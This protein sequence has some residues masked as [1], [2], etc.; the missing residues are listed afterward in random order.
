[1]GT[2]FIDTGGSSAFSGSSDSAAADLI[3]IS[4]SA[5]G[6]VVTL[7]AGTVLTGVI[8][9]PGPTQS[10]INLAGATNANRTIFW[11][12]AVAGSGGATPTVTV[13]VA[14]TGGPGGGWA[15]GGQYL[16]PSGGGAVVWEAACRSGDLIQYNQTPVSRTAAHF[17]GRNDAAGGSAPCRIIGKAGVRP[18][19]VVTNTANVISWGSLSNYLIEDL[20]IEQQGTSGNAVNCTGAGTGQ[21][22]RNVRI[23]D[24]G[25][26]GYSSA[27]NTAAIVQG[28]EIS[29]VLGDGV[30]TTGTVTFYGNNIHDNGGDGYENSSTSPSPNVY[31]NL[32]H[33]NYGRGIAFTGASSAATHLAQ[34]KRNTVALNGDSGL[35]ITD[36]DTRVNFD[37]NIFYNNGLRAGTANVLGTT[38]ENSLL[39]S[40]NCFYSTGTNLSIIAANATETTADPQFT[41]DDAVRTFVDGDVSTGADTITITGHGF[42][43]GLPITLSASGGTLPAPLAVATPYYVL[44][45]DA[46]TIQLSATIGGAAINI[47][48]AAGGGTYTVRNGSIGVFTLSST[49]PC[50]ATGWPGAF[51]SSGAVNTGYM[52][53]GALQRQEPAGGATV[54]VNSITNIYRN[55]KAA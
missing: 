53:M 12:S 11:I 10:S 27:N 28:N 1:M 40:N 4:W 51:L 17:T 15:I 39:H 45:T 42:T 8:T 13:D 6:T 18:K 35:A 54:V 29:G 50:K 36:V 30:N 48:S 38:N 20:D 7:D 22:M 41:T 43:A 24:A 16:G 14:P 19:L 52:D 34:V 37:N 33:S 31:N 26:H 32:I 21:S 49:S 9:T 23:L 25:G 3:G 47:T 2:V 55:R 44:V 46:N 5:A